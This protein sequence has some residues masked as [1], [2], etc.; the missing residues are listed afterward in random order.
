MEKP[1]L[2]HWPKG[3][4]E[5]IDYPRL[6]LG[7]FLRET[8]EAYPNHTATE[9]FRA[10]L[11]YAEV[12]DLADRFASGLRTLGVGKGDRVA[13]MMPNTPHFVIAFFGILR[14]GGVVVQTNPL[15]T[16]R[17]LAN[18]WKDSGTKVV[19]TLDIF[20]PRVEAARPQTDVEHVVVGDVADYLPGLLAKLY[21]IKKKKDLKKEGHWPLAIPRE[22]WVHAFRD[23]LRHAPDPGAE[24][25]ID[26]QE[27]VAVLQYTGGT[28]GIPK[29]AMLTHRN[30]V[31][32]T[33][34][35]VAWVPGTRPGEE[36][37][38]AA[39]PM[40]HV[41]GLTA[42]LLAAVRLG[43]AMILHPNP[44]EVDKVLKLCSKA[45]PTLF[46]GVPTLYIAM[47]NHP[48]L[49]KADLASIRYCISGAA[50]LPLEV[51][52]R[53]EEIT[54]GRLVEGYGLTEASP[55][56]HCNPLSEGGVV[57]EGIGI[58]FPDTEA[59]VVDI[60]SGT[61]EL[62]QGEA[63]ELV[64]RGPQV[65]KG[66]WNR[67]EETARTIRDGW[68]YTGDIAKVDEDGYF[69]IV[70]R[71]K[72]MIVASGFNVY[73]REV[74]EVLFEHPAV[75]EAAVI[76]VPD[77]YRGET[78]KAYVV[79]KE[80]KAATDEE[81]RAFCKERLASYKVPRVIEFAD[82]LPKTLVGKVLR[83]ALREREEAKAA[84]TGE[85]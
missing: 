45:E 61:A 54:G 3:V 33:L 22:E 44:R 50:P 39:I 52:R 78:V 36:R 12:D 84:K 26:P 10:K 40:F 70:D 11:T 19:V 49:A 7:A 69:F 24:P 73:P 16:A 1:W 65:M 21:P 23:L 2:A 30:L 38:M 66:Y 80:G 28:T 64:I 31:A 55:V 46:P 74:E 35:T 68:L 79:L 81:I 37:F 14:A 43:A 34:Q 18:M 5:H 77:E 27:D 58:P 72:D 57:K 53:F 32:N 20:W 71:K 29:G 85:A 8:A 63:G 41:Y 56:T 6:S 4:P 48:K 67:Q 51:R 60:E 75:M 17:E 42:V 13:L 47:L 76:G 62:P 25:D 82:E 15:Y 59:K 9:F 83:R